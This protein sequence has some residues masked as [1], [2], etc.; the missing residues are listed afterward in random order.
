[1][2]VGY[3]SYLDASSAIHWLAAQEYLLLAGVQTAEHAHQTLRAW[4]LTLSLMEASSAVV[5]A[6]LT[7]CRLPKRV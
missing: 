7:L 4:L 3:N 2:G 5:S 1:M 6:G